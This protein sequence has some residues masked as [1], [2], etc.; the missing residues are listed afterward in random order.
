MTVQL[1]DNEIFI[2]HLIGV[3]DLFSWVSQWKLIESYNQ[4]GKNKSIINFDSLM[5]KRFTVGTPLNKIKYGENPFIAFQSREYSWASSIIWRKFC[6]NLEENRV[7]LISKKIRTLKGDFFP[8]FAISI[9]FSSKET[10]SIFN[11][12]KHLS[13]KHLWYEDELNEVDITSNIYK[14]PILSSKSKDIIIPILFIEKEEEVL[15]ETDINTENSGNLD[16]LESLRLA[17]QI[18]NKEVKYIKG[19]EDRLLSESEKLILAG[20]LKPLNYSKPK[21]R[22]SVD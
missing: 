2:K 19:K 22:I 14:D 8:S 15:T 7:Y 11:G 13:L 12:K 16:I 3:T 5:S 18:K 1:N 6:I 20:F 10:L 4:S 17:L 9:E 21:I